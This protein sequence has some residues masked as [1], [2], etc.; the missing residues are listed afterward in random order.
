MDDF[1]DF[2]GK[3]C[4]DC[5]NAGHCLANPPEEDKP[6][7]QP[8]WDREQWDREPSHGQYSNPRR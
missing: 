4:G 8:F 1:C 2:Y 7:A 6:P 5:R 3:W